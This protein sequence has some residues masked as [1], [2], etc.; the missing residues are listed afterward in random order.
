M[1]LDGYE[2]GVFDLTIVGYGKD[3]TKTWLIE[4]KYGKNGY[5]PEQRAIAQSCDD[6]PVEAIQIR[7]LEEFQIFLKENLE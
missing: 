4:F 7:S 3:V 1:K 6:T 5:T 2:K